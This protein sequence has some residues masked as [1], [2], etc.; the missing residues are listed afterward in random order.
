MNTRPVL[1]NSCTAFFALWSKWRVISGELLR[2]RYGERSD[3]GRDSRSMNIE[4]TLELLDSLLRH[5]GH[6][7]RDDSKRR[8]NLEVIM[9][10]AARFGFLL[11]RQPSGWEFSWDD[12]AT[13]RNSFVIFPGLLQVADETGLPT[14]RPRFLREPEFTPEIAYS[15]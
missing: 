3:P 12:A 1:T 10:R 2:G 13:T 5:F 11:Y 9:H 14:S 8:N 15:G 4:K 6:E 7:G